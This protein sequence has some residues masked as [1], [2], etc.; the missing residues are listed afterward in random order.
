MR[1]E[2]LFIG[3]LDKDGLN[4]VKIDFVTTVRA[5]NRAHFV[6]KSS[7]LTHQKDLSMKHFMKIYGSWNKITRTT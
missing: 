6:E 2:R 5:I 4:K 7:S 3:M 1:N